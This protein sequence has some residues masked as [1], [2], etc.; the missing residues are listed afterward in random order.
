MQHQKIIL[1]AALNWGLGHASRCIPLINALLDNNY[2]VLIGS[3]GAALQLLRKEF[4]KLPFIVLASYAVKYPKNGLFFKLK[5]LRSLPAMKRAIASEQ[6]QIENLAGEGRIDGII[7]DNR[8]GAYSKRIPSVYLTHQVVV[9]SGTTSFL[10]SNIHQRQIKN[11][12]A[13]WIPDVEG[14]PNLSGALGHPGSID[15]P[16]RYLGPLSRLKPFETEKVYDV[17]AVLS[18]PEPQ[19]TLLEQKLK[20]VFTGAPLKVLLV[21]GI[22][23]EKETMEVRG[24]M[25][26]V[27]FMT[28]ASLERAMNES[29]LVVARSGYSTIMDLATLGIKAFFIPTPGQYE[30]NYLARQ[31][32]RQRI[33]PFCR[34]NQ[35]TLKRLKEV[36]DH[37]GFPL[38]KRDSNLASLFRLFEGE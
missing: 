19:R 17:L 9:L 36:D 22:M 10:S 26:V 4:P 25:T 31:L 37:E 34:Q 15:F 2:N 27:N 24:N 18:G 33:A 30:Q 14:S 6:K 5:L 3:D 8:P 16:V 29:K 23:E 12:D 35:F 28:T 38:I 7:S 1:V 21:R 20:S 11:F 13:C 32:K